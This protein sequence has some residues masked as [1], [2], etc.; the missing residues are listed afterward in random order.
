MKK[1]ISFA[2]YLE[3]IRESLKKTSIFGLI[4]PLLFCISL[5]ILRID[6]TENKIIYLFLLFLLYTLDLVLN[7]IK[8][9]Y[10][11][12][13][14]LLYGIFS[15]IFI[16]SILSIF[17]LLK[18][19]IQ[20]N[21]NLISY[22]FNYVFN[23]Y[24]LIFAT[25]IIIQ[26]YYYYYIQKRILPLEK[27]TKIKRYFYQKQNMIKKRINLFNLTIK[28][29]TNLNILLFAVILFLNFNG[30]INYDS[31]NFI[32]LNSLLQSNAT[33]FALILTL[34]LSILSSNNYAKIT[35]YYQEAL[36]VGWNLIF[37]LSY[38]I[39]IGINI[40]IQ[41]NILYALSLFMFFNT[42]IFILN[43]TYSITPDKIISLINHR[44]IQNIQKD[45][46]KLG[47][48]TNKSTFSWNAI[49]DGFA[50]VKV[51][52]K[53]KELTYNFNLLEQI[54]YYAHNIK[55]KE[56]FK[57][58][59]RNYFYLSRLLLSH[60][61]VESEYVSGYLY[62]IWSIFDNIKNSKNYTNICIEEIL[63]DYNCTDT[64]I[65]I[66]TWNL[67]RFKLMVSIL[68]SIPKT[69]NNKEK[70]ISN[71]IYMITIRMMEK[72]NIKHNDF[73]NQSYKQFKDTEELKE[74][75]EAI[76]KYT[77]SWKSVE[78]LLK[79]FKYENPSEQKEYDKYTKQIIRE[80]KK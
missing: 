31:E 70:I 75:K 4:Y 55:D 39:L 58:S 27:R 61:N 20:I 56:T 13:Y 80:L 34:S 78:S 50:D 15:I 32:S 12:I 67:Q 33:I 46:Y 16:W 49:K 25:F 72:I 59:I 37:F 63:N 76:K 65:D 62:P 11:T 26:R 38:L 57:N 10:R 23:E 24:I 74:L 43:L 44:I 71:L 28:Q 53:F 66:K 9:F 64:M 36:F 5:I 68:D 2:E 1:K 42:L 8:Y 14:W 7:I 52:D 69:Y 45:N 40:F 60:K 73:S 47:I 18:F 22:D 41:H 77:V 51:I 17:E 21:K 19:T 30:I 6:I 79:E 3:C 29:L 48:T 54:A 35:R